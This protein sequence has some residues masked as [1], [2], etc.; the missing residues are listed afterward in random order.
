MPEFTFQGAK[1][2]VFGEG[3]INKVADEIHALEG[4][5]VL[6][7][8][9]QGL[10]LRRTGWPFKRNGEG[11]NLGYPADGLPKSEAIFDRLLVYQIPVKMGD[12]CLETIIAAIRKAADIAL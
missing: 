1:K 9:D 5:K 4:K 2:I 10:T 7:V 8:Q 3:A 6:L 11:E 12:E